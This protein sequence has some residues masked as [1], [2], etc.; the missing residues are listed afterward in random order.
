MGLKEQNHCETKV[1]DTC[2]ASQKQH[3]ISE[4]A[5]FLLALSFINENKRRIDGH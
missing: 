3:K 1:I 5:Y 2:L 4:D